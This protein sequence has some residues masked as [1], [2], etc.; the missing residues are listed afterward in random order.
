MGYIFKPLAKKG[1]ITNV[2]G[3]IIT[4]P[5]YTCMHALGF[6]PLQG[7]CLLISY[8]KDL[9]ACEQLHCSEYPND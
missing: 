6:L 3:Y 2:L 8:N 4:L 7:V 5:Q 1:I 9:N